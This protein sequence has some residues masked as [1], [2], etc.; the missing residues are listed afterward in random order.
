M[1]W[2]DGDSSSDE[3]QKSK[4]KKQD[5]L[6]HDVSA[7]FAPKQPQTSSN[8]DSKTDHDDNHGD[9]DP[10]DAYMKSLGNPS[11]GGGIKPKQY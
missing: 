11:S 8:S 6:K 4:S 2:F 9:E 5:L 1:G 7:L 3:E 10:L